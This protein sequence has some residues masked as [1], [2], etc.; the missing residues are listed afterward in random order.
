MPGAS[1]PFAWRSRPPGGERI[2][3]VTPLRRGYETMRGNPFV[4]QLHAEPQ[5]GIIHAKISVRAARHRAGSDLEDLLCHHSYIERIA[6]S[7]TISVQSQSV[8]QF[9]DRSNVS[10]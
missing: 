4:P 3:V 6:P 1:R 5:P 8:F 10:F 2:S 7:V 9:G